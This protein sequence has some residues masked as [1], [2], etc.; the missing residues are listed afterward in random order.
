MSREVHSAAAAVATALALAAP[1]AGQAAEAMRVVRDP[2]TGELR[3]PTAA[4]AAAFEKAAAQLSRRARTGS[5]VFAVLGRN[6]G[7]QYAGADPLGRA[8]MYAP[9]PF[10]GGSSVSHFDRTMFRNQL[11]EPNISN[12]LGTSLLPPQDMS[13]RLLLDIGW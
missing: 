8:L 9:N 6:G 5:G 10:I 1:A 13:F 12:D 2:Q 4:E 11:M 7:A 3:G